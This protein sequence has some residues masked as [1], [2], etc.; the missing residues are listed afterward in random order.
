M[1]R[2]SDIRRG[3][4]DY[5]PLAAF[6]GMIYILQ[7]KEGIQAKRLLFLEDRGNENFGELVELEEELEECAIER[8]RM[9][10]RRLWEL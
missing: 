7:T 6:R 4:L 5:H 2:L 9:H 3:E 8:G 10:E 1:E